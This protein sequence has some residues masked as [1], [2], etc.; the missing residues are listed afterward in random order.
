MKYRELR[1][2]TPTQLAVR[3][4]VHG[5]VAISRYERGD[6]VMSV[7]TLIAIARAL[8]VPAAALLDGV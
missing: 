7:D 4:G 5:R 3:V 8:G 1:G 6:R 2:L